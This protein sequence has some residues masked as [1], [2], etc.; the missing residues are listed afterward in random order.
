MQVTATSLEK[1]DSI[2]EWLDTLRSEFTKSSYEFHLVCFFRFIN[3]TREKL[4]SP[5]AF[6]KLSNDDIKALIFRY[7]AHLK[8]VA[9]P[10]AGKPVP[11]E[12]SVN[13][14]PNLLLGIK[15]FLDHH[16]IPSPWW[17]RLK[18]SLPERVRNKYRAYRIE[19]IQ[20]MRQ[21]ADVFDKVNISLFTAGGERVGGQ[22]GLTFG[23]IIPL[24]ENMGL[25]DVYSQSDKWHYI[26][27]LNQEA[28]NDIR[29]CKEYRESMGET[30]TPDSPLVRDK[31]APLS[32]QTNKAKP[33]KRGA[34]RRRMR[35]LQKKADL[36]LAELQPSHSFRYFFDTALTNC[37][38][39]WEIKELMMGHSV[40]LEK[41]YYDAKSEQSRNKVVVEYMK[42]MDALTISAEFKMTKKIAEYEEKLKDAPKLEALQMS[43]VNKDLDI[44]ALKKAREED[45]KQM[46][47]L[48]QTV[49]QLVR[50]R[51]WTPAEPPAE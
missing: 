34:I 13:S 47:Y 1:F 46:D 12:I 45:K 20:K 42:A 30:I 5:S 6:I 7:V 4:L 49:N 16:E 19:E 24:P 38:C 32:R 26:V 11:G 21:H 40:K 41:I 39:K 10:H 51:N 23:S 37:D 3:S 36:P 31:F 15:S 17:K 44:G 28:M 14:I 8:K 50:Q 22:E 25:L 27:P 29:L 48:T 35:E 2:S 43:L 18:K 9:K 33:V